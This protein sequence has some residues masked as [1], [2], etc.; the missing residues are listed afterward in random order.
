M[1]R[2]MQAWLA[3]AAGCMP[4]AVAVAV[5][6]QPSSAPA[7]LHA[8]SAASGAGGGHAVQATACT[9]TALS[10]ASAATPFIDA[11]GT[12]WLAWVAGGSVSIARSS[13][14]GRSF[15]P[16][17]EV[18]H[19][20]SLLDLGADAKPQIVADAHGRAVVAYGVFKDR[21]YNA[22]VMVSTS[23]DGGATF[24]APRSLSADAA[25]Q[26]FPALAI[27][28]E[29]TVIA[30]WLDKRT[31]AAARRKGLVQ[32]GAALAQARSTDGGRTFV[33]ESIAQDHTCECCRLA[34]AIDPQGRPVVMYR[35]IFDGRERDHAVLAFSGNG[36]AGPVH[37]V[38]ADHWAID[39]CP[40]H[41]PSLAIDADGTY[42]A[43]WF[44]LGQARQG[45]YHAR[46]TDGGRSFSPPMA[47]GD[48]DQQPGRPTLLARGRSVWLAW[49]EFD[50]QRI[51]I[52]LR[53]SGDA[54]LTWSADKVVAETGGP[55]DHPLLVADTRHVHLSWLTRNEGYRLM[56]LDE[57]K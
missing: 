37:R 5:A 42:Q 43:A 17:V 28:G 18:G 36:A 26:R 13:D 40:H 55:A 20:G 7:A 21:N 10:C 54:G 1:V 35:S 16:P 8:K 23:L 33:G 47:I 2:W 11:R 50:G 46:S 3:L 48:A 51:F 45:L 4:F 31:T 57:L 9:G 52:K 39:G 24:S 38:A 6:A 14:G 22:Q 19:H 49:K 41:G 34:M 12:L 30:T 56:T 29:G 53:K 25:S 15:A 27:D 32:D 44:T